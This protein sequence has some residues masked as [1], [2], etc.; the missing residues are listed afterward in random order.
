MI[1]RLL[2]LFTM[3]S[4]PLMAFSASSIKELEVLGETAIFTLSQP[5]VHQVPSCVSAEHH[6]KW[7]INL[8]SLQGQAMYSLLVTAVS[9]EQPVKVSSTQRCESIATIEQA[10]GVALHKKPTQASSQ[11]PALYK[12]DGVTKLGNII[13]QYRN[14]TYYASEV[15][16]KGPSIYILYEHTTG[17][18]FL[19]AQCRGEA[20][21]EYGLQKRPIYIR[22]LD[23]YGAKSHPDNIDDRLNTKGQV[24]VYESRVEYIDTVPET[25]C[26]YKGFMASMY[27]ESVTK[28]IRYPHPL[29]GESACIIK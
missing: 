10:A 7:A 26:R 28:V 18:L 13:G 1:K 15:G 6:N 5:K 22:N 16:S 4:I 17:L 2:F 24:K 19:D 25:T 20:Y 23:Y 9:K 29:C 12:S 3:T 11:V 27:S 8:S 14:E 21:S